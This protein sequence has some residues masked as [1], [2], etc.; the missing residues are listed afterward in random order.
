QARAF[1]AAH[2]GLFRAA[3]Y[4]HHPYQLL[5]PPTL[6]SEPDSVTTAD[7]PRLTGTLDGIFRAYRSS[8]RIPIYNTEF[9]YESRPPSAFGVPLA[10]QAAYLNESEFMTY[11][12]PRVASYM[13]F[14]L[15]DSI[16]GDNFQTGLERKNGAL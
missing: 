7:I 6:A 1:P 4:A 10:Q 9:G 12:N 3:G 13:Q 16:A 2:P 14:L 15:R 8:R 11:R 5:L